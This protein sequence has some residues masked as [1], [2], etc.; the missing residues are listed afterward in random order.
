M[1]YL[2]SFFLFDVLMRLFF[3]DILLMPFIS[4]KIPSIAIIILHTIP[5]IPNIIGNG[6]I[7]LTTRIINP[8]VIFDT[9]NS[10]NV[11]STPKISI[12]LL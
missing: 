5:E 1:P 6:N 10:L 3:L 4:K 9:G 12:L 8:T 11:I 2:A 7:A